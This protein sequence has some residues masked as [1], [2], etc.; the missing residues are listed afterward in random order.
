MPGRSVHRRQ[1]DSLDVVP[2]DTSPLLARSPGL[3][4]RLSDSNHPATPVN[5]GAGDSLRAPAGNLPVALVRCLAT[6]SSYNSV[7]R[8]GPPLA[9][10]S[11]PISEPVGL[12]LL[13]PTYSCM[14]ADI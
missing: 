9:S 8:S 14:G 2:R 13:P 11:A 3:T 7:L 10:S 12:V 4:L 6:T 5:L 1:D